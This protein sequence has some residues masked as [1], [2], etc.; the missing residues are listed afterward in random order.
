MIN[1][2]TPSFEHQA[3]L[4]LNK[5]PVSPN[6]C[7]WEEMAFMWG[8]MVSFRGL[9]CSCSTLHVLCCPYLQDE[10]FALWQTNWGTLYPEGSESRR[11]ITQIQNT[12]Y[13]VNLV[14]NDFVKGSCLFSLIDEVLRFVPLL[15]KRDLYSPDEG[16]VMKLPT[17]PLQNGILDEYPEISENGTS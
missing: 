1:G 2:I 7:C 3:S 17:K 6:I 4:E 8:N 13:L 10:A 14:D 15:T 16:L 12:Y 5:C 11:I 9:C